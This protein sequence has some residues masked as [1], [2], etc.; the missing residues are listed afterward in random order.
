MRG[1]WRKYTIQYQNYYFSLATLHPQQEKGWEHDGMI[2]SGIAVYIRSEGMGIYH[3]YG[4][5]TLGKLYPIYVWT[6]HVSLIIIIII[7]KKSNKDCQFF[8][9]LTQL[10][11]KEHS[12]PTM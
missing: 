4:Q 6:L 5:M 11:S 8:I 1:G 3:G 12:F 7:I 2:G 10:W 9:G